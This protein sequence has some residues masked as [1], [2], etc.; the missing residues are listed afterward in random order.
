M[1]KMF[2]QTINMALLHV[3]GK[4]LLPECCGDIHG[5]LRICPPRNTGRTIQAELKCLAAGHPAID[6]RREEA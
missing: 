5:S 4:T 2:I 6:G 3:N 1:P